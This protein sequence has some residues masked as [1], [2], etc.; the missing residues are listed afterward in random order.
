MQ[1]VTV[2]VMRNLDRLEKITN[3]HIV[4]CLVLKYNINISVTNITD[5]KEASLNAF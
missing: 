3:K 4:K 1:C 2:C 5:R